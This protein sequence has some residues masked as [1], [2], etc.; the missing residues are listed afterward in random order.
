MD[1]DWKLCS[2]TSTVQA[3]ALPTIGCRL[4]LHGQRCGR[5]AGH[6]RE[7]CF[8]GLGCTTMDGGAPASCHPSTAGNAPRAWPRCP[9]E[10]RPEMGAGLLACIVT[11]G[12]ARG[13]GAGQPV[14]VAAGGA[15]ACAAASAAMEWQRR[16]C[17]TRSLPRCRCASAANIR[18]SGGSLPLPRP[19][20]GH[21]PLL[22]PCPREEF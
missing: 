19:R 9:P 8:G 11:G 14:P 17:S 16:P 12:E 4:L 1:G 13:L 21:F 7:E 2:S 15:P 5:V 6:G 22:R 3:A 20:S 18:R 10:G